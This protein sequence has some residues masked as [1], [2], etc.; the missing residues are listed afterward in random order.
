MNG[1]VDTTYTAGAA[2]LEILTLLL[3]AF[4]IGT[5][6]CWIFKQSGLCCQPR[7]TNP[8]MA[9]KHKAARHFR[10][11]D[12]KHRQAPDLSLPDENL[13]ATTKPPPIPVTEPDDFIDPFKPILDKP[14]LAVS[15]GS[16]DPF[17]PITEVQDGIDPFKSIEEQPELAVSDASVDPFKP[18]NGIDGA[19][20]DNAT[21][22]FREITE[23]PEIAVSDGSIDPFRKVEALPEIAV[24]DNTI[25]PF[26]EITDPPGSVTPISATVSEQW[27]DP[28]RVIDDIPDY[29]VSDHSIDPFKPVAE[30]ADAI[31]DDSIDPFRPII[32]PPPDQLHAN[33]NDANLTGEQKL[34]KWL[35]K[36]RS[37]VGQ[38]KEK[39]GPTTDAWLHKT[40]DSVDHL[41]EKARELGHNLS[42]KGSSLADNGMTKSSSTLKNMASQ[43]KGLTE[44]LFANMN[45][46]R[47]NLQRLEGIGPTFTLILNRAGI[48][49][50]EQLAATSPQKL[51]ALLI[52]EDEQFGSHDTS[53][54]PQ[55]AAMA[56]AG[57]WDELEAYQQR[58]R[59][60]GA[61]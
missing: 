18:F 57:Q 25:D 35:S 23:L 24:S 61:A 41:K 19:V 28:N 16:I 11:L 1:T 2:T 48:H 47:D 10:N 3:L 7:K 9:Q 27:V 39:A 13:L 50:Y 49:T 36:A 58:L 51:S 34:D 52:V 26:K 8:V 43:T 20:S 56:A 17:R 37:S 55:Q 12:N 5:L 21:N 31:S 4:V 22:P 32:A 44:K 29:A 54:W 53:S 40:K 38:L 33:A 6:V 15:D 60:E 59:G 30:Q 42:E 14:D 45:L 46:K